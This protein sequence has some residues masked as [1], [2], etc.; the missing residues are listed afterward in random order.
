MVT[1]YP[2]HIIERVREANDIIDVLSEFLPLKKKGRNWTCLCPFHHEKTPS[3]SVSQDKQIFHCFGCGAGGN[4][5]TFL[6][7]HEQ[8]TF[9]DAVKYLAKKANIPL[10]EPKRD[11]ASDDKFSRLYYAHEVAAE[12]YR[13]RLK[14]TEDGKR[15]LAY[16]HDARGLSDETI[17]EFGIGYA[18]DGWEN[19]I[20]YA[21]EKDFKIEE[22][23]LAGLVVEREHGDGCYDRFR[24]R[25]I[26]PI[27]DF[28]KRPIAFGARALSSQDNVKYLNSPDTP[29]YHKS[30][31]MYGLSHS[32][33]E[34]RSSRQALIVEGYMDFLALYQAGI[35]NTVAVSGTSFTKEHALILRRY[36]DT[37]L[38]LFDSDS[39]GQSATQ[40]CAEHLFPVG[41]DVRVVTL[42]EGEDPDSYVRE[43]G[44]E[45]ME[46]AIE[47]SVSF[48]Q[49][50]KSVADPPFEERNRA[51]RQM[52]I[53]SMLRFVGM[54]TDDVTQALML[55]ELSGLYELPEDALRAGIPGTAKKKVSLRSRGYNSV[56]DKNQLERKLLELILSDSYLFERAAEEMD[57]D[58]FEIEA[59]REIFEKALSL[60][61]S[62]T[63]INFASLVE[64][65]EDEDHINIL[66]SMTED[67]SDISDRE[68]AY[69][70]Y[71][72]RFRRSRRDSRIREYTHLLNEAQ[73]TGDSAEVNRILETL[74]RLRSEIS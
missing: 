39:A 17:D 8:M 63:T 19:L 28:S 33:T 18:P 37:V 50:A 2:D 56:S 31:T 34:I 65:M 25:L 1:L 57:V 64:M 61:E 14:D 70:E 29:L 49:F 13:S 71:M 48:F 54:V 44:R 24:Q 47:E 46:K 72:T 32:R 38:L 59:H 45:A 16:L 6:M 62:E 22:L 73:K 41:L 52:L 40:R 68:K 35:R 43:N 3:F 53:K 67:S 30:K 69:T 10:P 26:F 66:T 4:V 27:F 21:R 9:P 5:L 7:K 23:T 20:E 74:N 42:P 58:W 60:H 15:V 11:A 51:G 12:M 55:K 36:A